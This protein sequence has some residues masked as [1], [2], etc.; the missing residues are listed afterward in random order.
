MAVAPVQG[1]GRSGKLN[2]PGSSA[3][4][5]PVGAFLEAV[6]VRSA[7]RAEVAELV[8][9]AVAT[10]DDVVGDDRGLAAEDAAMAVTLEAGPSERPPLGR[11]VERVG[12]LGQRLEGADMAWTDCRSERSQFG[13][14][15]VST[16][17]NQ[18]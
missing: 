17:F 4:A 5:L 2:P 18:A 3:A 13:R 6:V 1:R 12:F 7:Q 9:A 8:A 14:P 16:P 11:Q 15:S 10:G